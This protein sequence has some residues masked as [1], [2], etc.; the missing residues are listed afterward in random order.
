MSWNVLYRVLPPLPLALK[1]QNQRFAPE[2]HHL[3][4]LTPKPLLQE[5]SSSAIPAHPPEQP[6]RSS[7][8]ACATERYGC[9]PT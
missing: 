7:K 3:Q 9:P 1:P 6:S 5:L 8:T 2:D 4:K